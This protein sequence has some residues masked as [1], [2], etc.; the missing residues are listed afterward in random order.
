VG[1][2][3]SSLWG[4][5]YGVVEAVAHHHHPRRV[6]SNGLDMVLLVYVTNILAHEREALE[7]GAPAPALD[8]EL[9]EAAGV[10]E[11]LPEWR[12]IAEAAH[13]NAGQLVG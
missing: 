7:S 6:P 13:T 2:Y 1:A 8:M 9:L 3:L 12:K 10:A 11:R 4:L 5:P